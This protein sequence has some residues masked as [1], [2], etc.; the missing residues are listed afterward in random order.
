MS[1]YD[2]FSEMNLNSQISNEDIEN[3]SIKFQDLENNN[4]NFQDLERLITD[5]EQN[6]INQ[7]IDDF[8][9]GVNEE[10]YE[11]NTN[12]DYNF[13]LNFNQYQYCHSAPF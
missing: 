3:N 5:Y 6:E 2:Q 11:K 8:N 12:E 10:I 4:I 1:P 13:H 7:L 9:M